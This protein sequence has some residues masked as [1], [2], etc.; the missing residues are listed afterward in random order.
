[1]VAT[2]AT[3]DKDNQIIVWKMTCKGAPVLGRPTEA[4]LPVTSPAVH[5]K[6]ALVQLVSIIWAFSGV[7]VIVGMTWMMQELLPLPL[8]CECLICI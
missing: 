7:M 2:G 5:D 1:M 4:S 3:K 6:S 8:Y